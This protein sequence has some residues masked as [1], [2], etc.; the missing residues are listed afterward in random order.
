M[1]Q[2]SVCGAHG[3]NGSRLAPALRTGEPCQRLS[4]AAEIFGSDSTNSAAG[5]RARLTR[6]NAP[7]RKLHDRRQL[8]GPSKMRQI[9]S[10]WVSL[11]ALLS[12]PNAPIRLP[13]IAV[14]RLSGQRQCIR[15]SDEIGIDACH[16]GRTERH[17]NLRPWQRESDQARPKSDRTARPD[18]TISGRGRVKTE[19]RA[20]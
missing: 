13:I 2:A 9:R 14:G 3:L 15:L 17:A 20:R 16:A 11:S 7:G 19:R 4:K 18:V 10:R 6:T 8:D 12:H 1:S 5:S